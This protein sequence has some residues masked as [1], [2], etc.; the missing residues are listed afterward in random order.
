MSIGVNS[1]GTNLVIRFGITEYTKYRDQ[2]E[3]DLLRVIP[4]HSAKRAQNEQNQEISR[5]TIL[6]IGKPNIIGVT[7]LPPVSSIPIP[8]NLKRTRPGP[9]C[10]IQ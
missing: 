2:K 10:S 5:K 4:V 7:P 6:L 9:K 8:K 3:R 1:F